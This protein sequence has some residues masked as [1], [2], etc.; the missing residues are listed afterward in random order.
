MAQYRMIVLS[1][2]VPGREAEF[3]EWYDRQHIPDLLN[4]PG[5]VAAQRFR[6]SE[7]QL[8]DGS[9]PLRYLA[10][11]EIETEDLSAVFRELNARRGT[12]ELVASDSFDSTTARVS[13]FGPVTRRITS[14]EVARPRKSEP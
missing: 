5:F 8:R 12:P 6:L 13:V 10:V 14:S 11:W 1:N 3:N 2:P 4:V 7:T 9:Q